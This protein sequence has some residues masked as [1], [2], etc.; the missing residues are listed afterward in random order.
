M[1]H[2]SCLLLTLISLTTLTACDRSPEY[3]YLEGETMGTSYHIRYQM[4]NNISEADIKADIDER[5]EQVSLTA[6]PQMR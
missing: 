5:L 1:K 6:Y 4:P 2:A 3:A